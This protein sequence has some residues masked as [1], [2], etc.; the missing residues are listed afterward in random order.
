[1]H[2]RMKWTLAALGVLSCGG[3]TARP[4]DGG[5]PAD[6]GSADRR[7]AAMA[8][9][10]GDAGGPSAGDGGSDRGRPDAASG[11]GG[12]GG[13]PASGSGI[14]RFSHVFVIVMENLTLEALQSS[15]TTPYLHQLLATA[16]HGADYHGVAHPSLPNYLTMT[17]GARDGVVACDCSPSAGAACDNSNCTA[18]VG[19]CSCPQT[20]AHLGDQLEASGLAWKSYAEDM[21]SPCRLAGGGKYTPRHVPFLYYT[22]LQGDAARCAAHVVDYG[23]LAGDLAAGAPAFSFIT[24]NLT[25]DMHTPVPT[26]PQNLANGDHWLAANVPPILASSAYLQGGLLIIVWDEGNT[27]DDPIPIFVLSPYA[28]QGGYASPARADHASLLATI[29]DGLGL[30][31]LGVAQGATPLADYFIIP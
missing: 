11:T 2:A 28:R 23:A 17:L 7:A 31:R 29:E 16:A 4:V 18:T 21:G 19:T 8:D 6:D 22:N 12:T 24:P 10:G 13:A 26:G 9:G 27:A 3:G 14:P 20:A 25:D 15:T 30:P 1:M 5:A